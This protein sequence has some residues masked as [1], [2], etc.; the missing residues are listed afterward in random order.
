LSIDP[1]T[2]DAETGNGFNRYAYANNSPYR[3][4][5]PDG[6][7]G[8]EANGPSFLTLTTFESAKTGV[9][10]EQ[11]TNAGSLTRGVTMPAVAVGLA[12]APVAAGATGAAVAVQ[13]TYSASVSAYGTLK[14]WG[15]IIAFARGIARGLSEETAAAPPPT[16]PVMSQ[17]GLQRTISE[18]KKQIANNNIAKKPNI[19]PPQNL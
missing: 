12:A 17:G 16:P 9:S 8:E 5:D 14:T 13:G 18:I 2:T 10:L 15:G 1:V 6:R 3:Y 4:I 19:T 11:A 7:E